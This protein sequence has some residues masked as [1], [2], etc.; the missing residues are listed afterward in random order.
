MWEEQH[1]LLR[2]SRCRLGVCVCTDLRCVCMCVNVRVCVWWWGPDEVGSMAKPF[3]F[4]SVENGTISQVQ[5][6]NLNHF[7]TFYY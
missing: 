1:V 5:T 3:E 2:C 7:L 4:Y 6:L